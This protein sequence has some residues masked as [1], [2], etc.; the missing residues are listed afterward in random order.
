[1]NLNGGRLNRVSKS[2]NATKNFHEEESGFIFIFFSVCFC[3]FV[4]KDNNNTKIK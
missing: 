3:F 2:W 1:M 4:Y